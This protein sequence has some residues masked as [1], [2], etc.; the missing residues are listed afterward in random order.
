[1]S[2]A[3]LDC[4]LAAT[5]IPLIF[6]VG[7]LVL[8]LLGAWPVGVFPSIVIIALLVGLAIGL[9]RMARASEAT[10]AK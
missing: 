7:L 2:V 3:S 5:L 6:I 10:A 8:F 9:V 1:M 4:M